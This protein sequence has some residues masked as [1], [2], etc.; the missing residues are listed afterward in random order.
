MAT[1]SLCMIVKNEEEY[2]ANC[3]NSVKDLVDEIIIVDTGST[4][5]TEEIVSEYTN[6]IYFFDFTDDFS[7]ARNY[8]FDKASKEYIF[9]LDA[10]DVLQEEDRVKFKE[11]KNRLDNEVG[12]VAMKY[13][14]IFDDEDNVIF[15]FY[16]ERLIRRELKPLWVDP[17]H[18]YIIVDADIYKTDITITHTRKNTQD[19]RN[20]KI[21]KKFL[22]EGNEL[23]QRGMMHY[24]ME[25]LNN[26]L[27]QEAI[28]QLGKFLTIK[29]DWDSECE[30][31]CLELSAC[32]LKL[33][34]YDNAIKALLHCFEKCVPR[35][36]ICCEIGNCFVCKKEYDNATF[37][38]ELTVAMKKVRDDFSFVLDMYLDFIPN[39]QLGICHY[40]LGDI[41]RAIYYNEEAIKAK[42]NNINARKNDTLYKKIQ[43]NA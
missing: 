24:G 5:N 29:S 16:K 9:W 25:L 39:Y 8:S 12:I 43:A 3:L 22:Y 15:S 26:N 18:E 40:S 2:I 30:W 38:F 41:E 34:E 11:L 19:E 6:N 10:D 23:S 33:H 21:Y 1:I 28:F 31:V 37:W 32:Y 27:I 35:A 7:S 4:D 14:Y 20:L 42:P 17:V 36:E 13:N